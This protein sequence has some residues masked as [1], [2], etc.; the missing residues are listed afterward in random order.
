CTRR[1]LRWVQLTSPDNRF[2]VW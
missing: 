2:D 1:L